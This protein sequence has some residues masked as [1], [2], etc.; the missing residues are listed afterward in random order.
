MNKFTKILLTAL[1]LVLVVALSVGG[2]LA[3]LTDNTETVTNTFT[4]GDINITLVEH[5]YDPEDTDAK[6][7][8]TPVDEVSYKLIPGTTYF[9]DPTLTLKAGSEK[10]YLF[11]K[12]EEI[13]DPATYLVYDSILDKEGNNWTQGKGDD[14]DDADHIPTNVWYRVMEAIPADGEDAE[15][16]LLAGNEV[17]VKGTIVKANPGTGEVVMP[18]DDAQPQLKYTAYAVQFDNVESAA[19]AWAMVA[20]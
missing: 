20:D 6:L 5:E 7:N 10:C 15:F 18:A 11:V 14:A 2:T 4:V 16:E 17:M 12:F 3:W 1:C 8:D 9:K 13:N 19:D